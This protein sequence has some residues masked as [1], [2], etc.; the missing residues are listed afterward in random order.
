M[1]AGTQQVWVSSPKTADT[2]SGIQENMGT[3]L[4]SFS[5]GGG[6]VRRRG[7]GREELLPFFIFSH[8]FSE[9]LTCIHSGELWRAWIQRAISLELRT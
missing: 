7:P 2:G 3:D 5:R 4:G 1:I 8:S 9:R 6:S